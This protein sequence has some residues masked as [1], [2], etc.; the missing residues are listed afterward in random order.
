MLAA[1]SS[2]FAQSET[3]PVPATVGNL[4]PSPPAARSRRNTRKRTQPGPRPCAG[5]VAFRLLSDSVLSYEVYDIYRFSPTTCCPSTAVAG[6]PADAVDYEDWE[7]VGVL[8]A[9]SLSLTLAP[10][11]T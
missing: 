10:T 9:V 5:E 8:T 11:T 2:A 7:T 3:P 4:L 1:A 6:C